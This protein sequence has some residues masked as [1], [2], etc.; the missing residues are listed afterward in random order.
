MVTEDQVAESVTCGPD[1]EPILAQIQAYVDAG[2]DHVYLHQVGPDQAGFIEFASK[3][4][5][6]AFEREAVGAA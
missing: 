1:P 6:P 4:L 2:F 3:R 5:L